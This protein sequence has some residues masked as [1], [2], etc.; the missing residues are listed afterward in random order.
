VTFRDR[1]KEAS[2]PYIAQYKRAP[3][4]VKGL[5]LTLI[6]LIILPDPFDWIPGIA[7]MDE[8][9][10]AYLLLGLLHRYGAVPGEDKKRPKDLVNDI[11]GR[12]NNGY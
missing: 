6:G 2:T 10:Y 11:L 7:F 5:T 3:W 12:K 8:L 9:L 1:V 4:W